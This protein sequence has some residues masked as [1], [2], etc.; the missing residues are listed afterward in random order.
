MISCMKKMCVDIFKP[1]K[2]FSKRFTRSKV[3]NFFYM[4]FLL[5]AGLFTMLPLIY[6]I[7]TSFKPIDEL[8]IFPPRFFVKRPTI[9][10]YLVLPDLLSGLQIP[11]SR[12][13]FNSIF[14][15]IVT[16]FL[17]IISSS[18]A[19][20]ALSK[21]KFKGRN[22]Y[23]WIIQ[24]ALMFN[25]YT[26]SIPSY[27]VYS[28]LHLIDTYWIYILPNLAST[29]GVFLVKQYIEGYVPDA[30]LEAAKID[31]AGYFHA[32]W[33]IVMPTIKPA[34]LTLTLFG[35]RDI[36]VNVPSTTIFTEKIKTLPMITSQITAGGIA[37]SGSAMAMTV[38]MMIPP[39]A[40]YL[41]SQSNVIEAMT[42]AGIKE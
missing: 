32:F 39:I 31:G 14:V 38:I 9:S 3:G 35:F 33:K 18:M 10:N 13:I 1:K 15:S 4:F 42:S 29:L 8:L 17:Y 11:F 7:L 16:T 27:L 21:G 24:I 36:W 41:I 2:D 37:R 25:T 30:L 40:V 20:F 12:Y 5:L 26:L 19:A 6:S 28:K 34:W 23:F 22:A